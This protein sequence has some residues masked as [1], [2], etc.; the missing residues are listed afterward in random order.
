MK[1]DSRKSYFDKL[2]NKITGAQKTEE[3]LRLS[4]LDYTV[5]KRPIF[6]KD[7]KEIADKFATVRTDNEEVLGIVGQDY[8][9]LQNI[10]GFDF[11][12]DL[13]GEGGADFEAA[14]SWGK[15]KKAFI[16]AKT[17][18]INIHGDDF[19][20]YILFTNTHDGS[21]SIKAMFTPI[22]VVCQNT[23]V[24]AEKEAQF[25]ISIKHTKNAK[26]KLKIAKEVL[27][28]NTK[29]LEA[30]KKNA[31]ILAQTKLSKDEFREIS[32]EVFGVAE[33]ASN[34]RKE[35]AESNINDL[36]DRYEAPDL[37]HMEEHAWR[38][39]QAVSDYESHKEPI[40]NTQNDEREFIRVVM[41]M[42]LLNKY[43]EIIAKRK[44]LRLY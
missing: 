3:A 39:I 34:I 7:G 16:V 6:L 36:M 38:A 4:G 24:L 2:G 14:G 44:G 43:L 32:T 31:D 26:D 19:V 10:E 23:L 8:E 41:G 28:A 11:M 17:D 30:L 22:R 40:R 33:D 25:K 29:Y 37:Q 27:L 12:D 13:I 20:P 5:E 9:V 42:T 35:R 18:P 1:F 21:G 15:G